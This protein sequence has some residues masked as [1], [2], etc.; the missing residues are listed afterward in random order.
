M[1]DAL[2]AVTTRKARGRPKLFVLTSSGANCESP[3]RSGRA[4]N[5]RTL[6]FVRLV[7]D[8]RLV[9]HLA[10]E[11][12]ELLVGLAGANRVAGN[13]ALALHRHVLRAALFDQDQVPAE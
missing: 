7:L 5:L 1:I 13:V 11:L 12:A 9:A 6:F 2:R 3:P 4:R 8:L 10:H